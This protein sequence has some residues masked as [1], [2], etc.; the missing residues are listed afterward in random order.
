MSQRIM[1]HS[2]HERALAQFRRQEERREDESRRVA[3]EKQI[4]AN[5]KTEERVEMK[6]Y[7]RMMQDEEYER[8]MEKAFLKVWSFFKC[9]RNIHYK[10]WENKCRPLSF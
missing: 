8:Q 10:I 5:L 1:T 2:L 4:Q 6:R 7:L 9:I 3:K